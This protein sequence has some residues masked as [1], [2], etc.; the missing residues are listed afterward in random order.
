GV[1]HGTLTNPAV[2]PSAIECDLPGSGEGEL[3]VL[4][5]DSVAGVAARASALLAV[6]GDAAV[7][8]GPPPWWGRYPFGDGEIGLRLAAP[9]SLVPELLAVLRDRFGGAI[10][11]RGS[12]GS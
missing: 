3:A 9:V 7:T 2:V 6:L 4:L 8:D 11:V 12:L 5:E 10:A 1:V